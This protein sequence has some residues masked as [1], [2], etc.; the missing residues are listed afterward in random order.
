MAEQYAAAYPKIAACACGGLTVTAQRAP[1]FVHA[2]ACL[3][4]QRGTGSAFSYSAFFPES[5]VKIGGDVHKLAAFVGS[6]PLE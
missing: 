1:Q 4:C 5:A 2:C 3:D 6:G